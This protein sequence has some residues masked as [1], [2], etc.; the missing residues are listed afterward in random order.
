M[1]NATV[2]IENLGGSYLGLADKIMH[3]IRI[4]DNAA[5]HGWF[6]DRTP[7][8]DSEFIKPAKSVSSPVVPNGPG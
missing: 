5:G 6:V 1:R 8:D 4:D 3:G 2:T 7:R